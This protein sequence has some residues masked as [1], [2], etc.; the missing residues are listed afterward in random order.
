VAGNVNN[1]D[2]VGFLS[3]L[4]QAIDGHSARQLVQAFKVCWVCP[5]RACPLNDA[6]LEDGVRTCG[7]S[8]TVRYAAGCRFGESFGVQD[9]TAKVLQDDQVVVD[10]QS[11]AVPTST[12]TAANLG[13]LTAL[14]TDRGQIVT[15]QAGITDSRT[16]SGW[17]TLT[18]PQPVTS[19]TI[20]P[21]PPPAVV[22]TMPAS[23]ND[24]EMPSWAIGVLVALSVGVVA[25][26]VLLA[27]FLCCYR[28]GAPLEKEEYRETEGRDLD[29]VQGPTRGATVEPRSASPMVSQGNA[30][31]PGYTASQVSPG[32]NLQE[33]FRI[34]STDD[35]IGGTIVEQQKD[36]KYIVNWDNGTHSY[37]VS[38]NAFVPA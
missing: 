22:P 33:G 23:G 19:L 12:A 15:T 35:G 29:S 38:P 26:C 5:L 7:V 9:R 8:D 2:V 21:I 28:S 36:G 20:V 37:H 34:K 14:N 3:F 11:L 6:S 25:L 13:V 27:V 1:F 10:V 16:T 24:D 4:M 17:V 32:A 18:T 31:S 30:A